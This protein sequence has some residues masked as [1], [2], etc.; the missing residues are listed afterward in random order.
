M[1]TFD[2][3]LKC[4]GS[5]ELVSRTYGIAFFLF[6][7]LNVLATKPEC[8][9][10]WHK[11]ES[12][13]SASSRVNKHHGRNIKHMTLCNLIFTGTRDVAVDTMS[14]FVAKKVVPTTTITSW[15]IEC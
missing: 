3:C 14:M 6:L 12:S 9:K 11:G 8:A 15:L 13:N 7:H 5:V 2:V 10:S 1:P 4:R